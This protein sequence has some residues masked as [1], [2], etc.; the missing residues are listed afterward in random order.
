MNHSAII[1]TEN[2]T[3]IYN[4]GEQDVHALRG[5]SIEINAGEFV[6]VMGASG[7][8]K[9]TFLNMLGCLDE[10]TGGKYFLQNIEVGSMTRRERAAIRSEKLG[11]VFQSFNLLAR[12]SAIENV[13]LPLLYSRKKITAAQRRE[14][15]IEML[16]LVG[17]GDRLNHIPS[18]LSGGQQQRVAI[19]RALVNDP[20]LILADEATGNL[21]SK[22]SVE[23]LELMT[24]L[25]EKGI[26][27]IFVTHDSEVAT[28]MN[29]Q[30]EFRDGQIIDDHYDKPQK[31]KL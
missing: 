1:R 30:I 4:L 13:E 11:F 9:S 26:T 16:S 25:N 22:T 7:S 20:T 18:Q 23:I 24:R 6:A 19:A 29:R 10:P 28:W 8:G 3:K 5:I 17:L 27:I 21:D 15:A 14:K 31:A 12:T 2:L